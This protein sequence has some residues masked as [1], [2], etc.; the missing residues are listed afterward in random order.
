MLKVQVLSEITH[1][2]IGFYRS[3]LSVVK[4]RSTLAYINMIDLLFPLERSESL[5]HCQ[6]KLGHMKDRTKWVAIIDL[7]AKSD[8][9]VVFASSEMG[10]IFRTLE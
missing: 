5:M 2:L 10:V 6:K 8:N 7:T 9:Q 3:R 1:S 4:R